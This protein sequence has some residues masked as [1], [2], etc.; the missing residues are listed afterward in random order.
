MGRKL[1]RQ[2]TRRF[3]PEEA[4]REPEEPLDEETDGEQLRIKRDLSAIRRAVKLVRK[5]QLSR[6][7]RALQSAKHH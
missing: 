1:D 7:A 2:I 3:Y 5:R 6:G 4:V